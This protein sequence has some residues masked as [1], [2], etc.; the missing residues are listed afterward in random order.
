MLLSI[1]WQLRFLLQLGG[2]SSSPEINHSNFKKLHE[3]KWKH[4]VSERTFIRF[5]PA[6]GIYSPRL[7]V[8]NII[9]S[10]KQGRRFVFDIVTSGLQEVPGS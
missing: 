5:S 4:S 9:S 6:D 7:N 8:L 10:G 2:I 3:K 1:R